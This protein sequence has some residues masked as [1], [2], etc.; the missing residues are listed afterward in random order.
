MRCVHERKAQVRAAQEP[1]LLFLYTDIGR[2]TFTA[3]LRIGGLAVP[4]TLDG[5]MD[6]E[7]FRAYVQQILAPEF[8]AGDVVIMDNL[9][10]HK[11]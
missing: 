6:G 2:T 4:M 11:G 5:P 10:A 3:G 8:T 1:A 9:P 7:A